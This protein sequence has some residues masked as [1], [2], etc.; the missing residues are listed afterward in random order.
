MKVGTDAV[1]LATL[2]E[3]SHEPAHIL[4]IGTGCGVVALVLAQRFSEA[5]VDA[6][7][8]DKATCSVASSN[9]SSSPWSGRMRCMH[10]PLQTFSPDA[11]YDMI[12]CNPPYFRNSLHNRD[13]RKSLARHDDSLDIEAL[14]QHSKRLLS[15]AGELWLIQPLP[16]NMAAKAAEETGLHLK[17]SIEIHNKPDDPALLC[18]YGFSM[19][20]EKGTVRK[21]LYMRDKNNKYSD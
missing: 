4:D 17:S 20:A 9:F 13:E 12:A 8:I 16:Y 19:S 11:K 18:I 14:V 6:I 3:P 7:D 15:R 21:T 2:A 5:R 1:L 10:T